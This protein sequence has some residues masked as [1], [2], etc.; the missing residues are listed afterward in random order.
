MK[1]DTHQHYWHYRAEAL[2]WISEAMPV[3]RRD[4]LPP[5]NAAVMQAA[6][7]TAALA[8]QARTEAAE[9]DFLLDLADQYP[10]VVGV[11]GWA[12]LRTADL[13]PALESWGQHSA[14][15]GLRHLLQ[16]EPDVAAWVQDRQVNDGLRTLQRQRLTYDVLVFEHQLQDVMAFCARHDAH[17]LVLDHVGKPRLRD[18][19]PDAEQARP[20][21]NAISALARLPHTMCKLSGLVTE[22]GLTP[23]QPLRAEADAIR[24]CFDHALEAFGPDRILFG[25]D[26]PVCELAAGYDLVH[27]LA[28]RWAQAS[29]SPAEQAAFWSGNAVRCYSL[30]LPAAA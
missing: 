15:K 5:D 29:L 8:V 4:R 3:L 14:F 22:S 24:A 2:P 13:T 17:W 10:A 27:G 12:D 1:I 25:S 18:G 16:D 9:T 6:G 19:R 23:G 20:W 26:W 7:V 11:V 28:D 21:R 30:Q